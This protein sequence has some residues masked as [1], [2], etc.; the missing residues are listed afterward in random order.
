MKKW[1]IVSGLM[2]LPGIAAA[3]DL[4]GLDLSQID[5]AKIQSMMEQAEI[6]QACLA[7]ADQTQLQNLQAAAEN[8]GTEID[9]LCQQGK[10]AEAQSQAVTYGQQL[11]SEPLVK[12]FQQC[13]GIADL[14]L[15]L[16]LWA[17]VG[18]DGASDSHVCSLREQV[19]GA[20]AGAQ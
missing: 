20:T 5:A 11:I 10:R 16:A 8:K 3:Q 17:Q 7:K 15:P 6:V 9:A 4:G 2:I 1:L 18:S 13:V 14:T 12:D 19:V